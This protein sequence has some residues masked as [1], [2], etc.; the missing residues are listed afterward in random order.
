MTRLQNPVYLIIK[1]LMARVRT[2]ETAQL[3][4]YY[5]N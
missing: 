3:Y 5:L 2:I 1:I 4:N